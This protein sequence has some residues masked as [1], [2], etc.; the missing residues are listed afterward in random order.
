MKQL[1]NIPSPR[2]LVKQ[3]K[4]SVS[5]FFLRTNWPTCDRILQHIQRWKTPFSF[6]SRTV[7]TDEI[8]GES[9][10]V[11]KKGGLLSKACVRDECFLKIFV[12]AKKEKIATA[13]YFQV[14]CR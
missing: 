8:S 12:P 2:G 9:K 7:T 1:L 5:S 3:R 6:K 11:A 4:R 14:I 10:Y 13:D